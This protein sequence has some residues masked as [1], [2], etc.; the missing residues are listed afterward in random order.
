[1]GLSFG[2]SGG[3][4]DPRIL[5]LLAELSTLV[6]RHNTDWNGAS[7]PEVV[8]FIEKH[9]NITFVDVLTDCMHTF[10]E[11]A[12][13][14]SFLFQGFRVETEKEDLPEDLP[15]DSWQSPPDWWKS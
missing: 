8:E 12:E 9:K 11:V 10:K 6:K 2:R 3:V 7:A 1:M 15:R 5:R 13:P 4:Q 14:M